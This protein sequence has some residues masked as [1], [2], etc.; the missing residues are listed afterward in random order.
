MITSQIGH[1]IGSEIFSASSHLRV[2]PKTH[3]GSHNG[4][5]IK[6]ARRRTKS[7]GAIFHGPKISAIK[8]HVVTR[9]VRGHITSTLG[10]IGTWQFVAYMQRKRIS[11]RMRKAL[12]DLLTSSPLSMSAVARR[13]GLSPSTVTRISNGSLDPTT[14]TLKALAEALGYRLPRELPVL[15]NIEA[16]HTARAMLSGEMPDSPWRESLE[17]WAGADGRPQDLAREAGRAAPLHLRLEVTTIRTN[18]NI[19]RIAGAVELAAGGWAL[20]GW[21]AAAAFGAPE[22]SEHPVLVY[23]KGGAAALGFALPD[24]PYGS[25]VVRILPFDGFSEKGAQ[26]ASGIVWADPLQVCLD[27]YADPA[28][29]YLGD[30]L[31]DILEKGN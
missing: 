7:A 17:R 22:A 24:D 14:S 28:T 2:P 8:R 11:L 30:A 1:F 27:L 29:E 21:P 4:Q 16:V 12:V 10:L 31:L 13:A 23:A 9:T 26:T 6:A 3:I 19:L 25:T 15:C 18:W 5:L 20:S